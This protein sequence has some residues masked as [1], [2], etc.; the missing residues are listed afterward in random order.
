MKKIYLTFI[1][2]GFIAFSAKTQIIT[3]PSGSIEIPNVTQTDGPMGLGSLLW[4]SSGGTNTTIQE[5]WGLNLTGETG[6][7]VKI[8]N[9]SLLIGYTSGTGQNFGVGNALVSGN[10]GIGT[11][12]PQ[13]RLEVSAPSSDVASGVFH[14]TGGQSWG[15]VLTL[16]TDNT[17][18]LDDAR[19]LFS[20]RNKAKQW[21]VGG[22]NNSTK[23]S[24]WE[25]AGDGVYGSGWGTERLT[26]VSGGNVG[27]G[28]ANPGTYKL[29][30]NGGIHSQSVQIDMNGWSD[31]V[32]KPTYRLQ[33]LSYLKAFISHNHHLPDVPSEE[34]VIKK[35]VDLGEMNKL[36]L[37]KV[38]ELTLYLIEKDKQANEQEKKIEVLEA[39]L[40]M[41]IQ[42]L[43]KNK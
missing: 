34:E 8:Y 3:H 10:V 27:I 17:N 22:Y 12:S 5:N 19:L 40:N 33:S 11:L 21:A 42:T 4:M 25:D 35:G 41:L 14:L 37:K 2:L 29:A 13:S 20:Y 43:N 23:F 30:V 7:P 6:R 9:A 31:Y 26:I 18:G 28:T 16:A 15:N 32:F 36:L 38:E 39:K 1:S 24:I